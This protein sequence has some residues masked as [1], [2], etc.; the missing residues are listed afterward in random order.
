MSK[1]S[2]DLENVK[3]AKPKVKRS[4]SFL[5]VLL[6][7]VLGA[8]LG[9]EVHRY[10][11]KHIDDTRIRQ[12]IEALEKKPTLIQMQPIL[13]IPVPVQ[14]RQRAPQIRNDNF[15]ASRSIL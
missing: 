5:P 9:R 14:P 13:P 10:E 3:A 8:L 6:L 7:L 2:V 11:V 15:T 4:S 12:L 1:Y